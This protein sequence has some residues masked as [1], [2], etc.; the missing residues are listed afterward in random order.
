MQR[1]VSAGLAADRPRA[2]RVG[3]ARRWA[4]CCGPCGASARSGAPAGGRARRSQAPRTPAAPARRPRSRPTSAGRAR[5]TSRT[6]R[7][8][9]STVISRASVRH[10]RLRAVAGSRREA[11]LDRQGGDPEQRGA[12]RELARQVGLAARDLALELVL[13][14]G[15]AIDPGDD[16]E[17]PAAER[18][19]RE[20]AVPAIG[21]L[22]DRRAAAPRA[23]GVRREAGSAPLPRASRGRRARASPHTSTS[24]AERALDGVAAAVDLRPD[25]LDADPRRPA[26]RAASWVTPGAASSA[27]RPQSTR[28]VR[29]RN[30][31]GS[32]GVRGRTVCDPGAARGGGHEGNAMAGVTFDGVSKVYP[33]GTRAVD[34]LDLDIKDGEFMVLV[35]PSGC[36]KT[37]ALRMLAGLEDISE[38]RVVDRRPRR[39][40]RALARPRHRDGVPELRALSAPLA[41]TRTSPSA[42]ASR[43]CRRPRSTRASRTRRASSTSSRCSTASRARSRA[44]SASAWPWAAR[45]CAT[46]RP[47]SWT[48]RSP[49]STRSCAC[50]PAP[51]SRSLQHDLGVTTIYVTHDQVE[52]LTM[53]DRVAVMRKGELQQVDRLAGALRPAPQPLRRRLHRQPRDEHAGGEAR[54]GRR[55]ATRSALGSQALALDEEAVAGH[56]ALQSHAGREVILGIRPEDLEDAT[57]V[58]DDAAR[59]APQGQGGA[60]RGARLRGHGALLG[61]RLAGGHRGRCTSSRPTSATT[62]PPRAAVAGGASGAVVVGRFG[63]RSRVRTGDAIEIAVD[64]R[65]LHFFDPGSA[66]GIYDNHT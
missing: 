64:T 49:I 41:C 22:A 56:P 65:S 34:R 59:P 63:A 45:S 14:G 3:A 61:R 53:G 4:R 50:R 39:Q 15:D 23:S 10:G 9:R 30:V 48:S 57:L 7:A 54:E 6:W 60:D 24:V 19:D 37:T 11:L 47:S 62:A 42:C 2:A 26:A 27:S 25:A 40:P 28:L 44:G 51:R 5:T 18:V 13:P 55:T 1:G 31:F 66:L 52:A 20:R 43:R 21:I 16:A 36:G 35:G 46:R 12:L 32:P 38:G 17:L 33:D 58:P 29:R 8:R